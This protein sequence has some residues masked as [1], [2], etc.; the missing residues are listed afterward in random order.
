MITPLTYCKCWKR[1]SLHSTCFNFVFQSHTCAGIVKRRRSDQHA[2]FD[3]LVALCIS[4]HYDLSLSI[5]IEREREREKYIYGVSVFEVNLKRSTLKPNPPLVSKL[6]SLC[7][8]RSRL[9]SPKLGWLPCGVRQLSGNLRPLLNVKFWKT[10]QLAIL[11][12]GW[13]KYDSFPN[14]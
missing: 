13:A 1:R 5:Y 2:M 10:H 12:I 3:K 6:N 11:G 9:S 7:F 4:T 14:I 8:A